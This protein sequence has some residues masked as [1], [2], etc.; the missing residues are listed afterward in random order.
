MV[1]NNYIVFLSQDPDAARNW[2]NTWVG[3]FIDRVRYK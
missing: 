3:Q 1:P 2:V